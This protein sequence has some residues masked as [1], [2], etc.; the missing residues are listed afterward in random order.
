VLIQSITKNSLSLAGFALV[1]AGILA[2]TY[3]ATKERIDAAER[4]AAQAALL[5]I[6]PRSRHDN[7][8][9]ADA[10]VV[11]AEQKK[12]LGLKTE[13]RIHIALSQGKPVAVIL[14][15]V[16]PD[17]Y[18]GDIKIIVGINMDGSIAGVRALSHKETPGLGDRV[19]LRKSNWVL[20]FDGKSLGNPPPEDW[21]VKKDGG[22]F[23]QFTGATITPR[24]VVKRVKQT[25]EYFTEHKTDILKSVKQQENNNG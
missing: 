21:A 25:L 15:A 24:A 20:S 5:E 4:A 8:M 22:A 13:E 18:S 23:D 3:Q 12:A 16:A 2:G 10:I 6:V 14:P 9:L 1:T 17:G 19:D 7:D 11:S